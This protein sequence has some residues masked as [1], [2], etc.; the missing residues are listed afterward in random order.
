LARSWCAVDQRRRPAPAAAETTLILDQGAD[1]YFAN[2][3]NNGYS[4]LSQ[5]LR[6]FTVCPGIPAQSAPFDGI[7]LSASDPHNWDTGAAY[8]YIQAL[9]THLNSTYAD[10][11]S[12]AFAQFPDQSNALSGDSSVTPTRL[13]RRIRRSTRRSPTTT[14]PWPG[15]A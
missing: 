4:Y 2:Y 12:N 3:A 10:P 9:L 8:S 6:L 7:P 5:D 11:T 13:N 15:C 1:P 14:S